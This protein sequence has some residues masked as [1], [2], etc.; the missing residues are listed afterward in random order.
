MDPIA[1]RKIHTE[2]G[3]FEYAISE[4][5]L[6]AV[7]LINGGGGPIEGWYKVFGELAKEHT[8]FAYNRLGIGG[9]EKPSSPQDG[10]AIVASLENLLAAAELPP[11]YVLTGHSLGGL[12]ANLFAR[13][14]P[15]RTAG[16]VLLES[17]HPEDLKINE[18]QNAFVLGLNRLL[19]MF[20]GLSSHRK[21]NEV[22]FVEQTVRQLE[23][24]GPFPDVPLYVV[25][26]VKKPPGMPETVMEIRRRNQ[27]DLVRLS[28]QGKHIP[29]S[30]SGHFPQMTEPDVVIRTI[31]DC[32][33][34]V[35]S[36]IR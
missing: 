20:D 31:R 3:T 16:V 4:K 15:D 9:S 35:N 33:H 17:S 34:S 36:S 23:Q 24:A 10:D 27:L 30:R 7:V 19:G 12:Y 26:G 21:W 2:H 28:R 6:P 32:I 18:K 11:P 13:R 22:H 14:F 8:V 25:S 5:R 1:K 29:A